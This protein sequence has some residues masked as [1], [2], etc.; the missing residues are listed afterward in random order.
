MSA[1]EKNPYI[2]GRSTGRLALKAGAWYV[3]S[4]LIIRGLTFLT[5]PIFTRLLS[6]DEYGVVR[7]YE[8][9]MDMLLPVFG[10]CIYQ[11]MSRAKLD[12]EKDYYEYHSSV[13]ALILL[14]CAVLAAL[15]MIFRGAAGRV[16]SMNVLMM[17]VMLCFMPMNSAIATYQNREKQLLH[18]R[19]N[20]VVMALVAVPA[21]LISIAA[22]WYFKKHAPG[23]SLSDVRIVSFYLPQIIVGLVITIMVFVRGRFTVK[24]SHWAYALKFSLPLIPH[25]LSMY[26]LS[27]CD[28]LMIKSMCGDTKAAIFS[29]AV[30]LQY[31][32]YVVIDAVEGSWLPWLFEKLNERDNGDPALA[33]AR[34]REIE[35][36]FIVMMAAAC[37]LALMLQLAA[38]E[39]IAVLG[40]EPYADARYIIAPLLMSSLFAFGSRLFVSIEK[41][42]KKTL[43]TAL[44][45]M[46]V[47]AVNV[48][49]N[50]IFIKR[51][52]YI[53]AA[54]TTAFCYML[55]LLIH[56]G[57]VRLLIKEDCMKLYKPYGMIL[58]CGAL[59][60][61]V[62]LLYSWKYGF[63]V[64]YA[65]I[66]A[67]L[68]FVIIRYHGVIISFIKN[69][70]GRTA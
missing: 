14:F 40:G 38:P 6:T 57:F 42:N 39:L 50:Y 56:A 29:L 1:Q 70:T 60:G 37:G 69:K 28:R 63:I 21:T 25:L 68:A 9:W 67:A 7:V 34:S 19:S 3:V 48:P 18:Y 12:F 2:A 16:L 20:V 66:A 24:L 32:L 64:R 11:S 17:G 53:A 45:T 31:V 54:Y 33:K 49:L 61:L 26:V 5:T 62:M 47:A 36:P 58:A 52:G 55:L 8:T 30:T 10:L 41:Y 59:L 4:Q 23:A 27:Q 65:A 15:L 43:L 13:Q 44:C 22:V 46:L 51:C 35:K